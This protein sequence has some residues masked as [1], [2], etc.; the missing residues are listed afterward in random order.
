MNLS[1]RAR[2]TIW[3]G[4]VMG[5]SLAAFGALTFTSISDELN[6]GLDV[7]L[8]KVVQGL[9]GLIRTKAEESKEAKEEAKNT[10]KA[11]QARLARAKAAA[12]DTSKD[13]LA[14]LRKDSLKADTTVKPAIKPLPAEGIEEDSKEV[15]EEV[16]NVWTA[17]YEFI[18]LNPRNFM[19]QV[20]DSTGTIVYRSDNLGEDSLHLSKGFLELAQDSIAQFTTI[21]QKI[22]HRKDPQ[23]IRIAVAKSR[24]AVIIAGYPLDEIQSSTQEYFDT[25]ILLVPA[26]LLVSIV[27]GWFLAKKSLRPVDELTRTA[28]DITASNLSRRL[29]VPKSSDEIGRLSETLNDMISRLESSFE[30]I[31]QF[32]ADASHELRTPLT[33]LTGEMELALRTEKSHEEYQEV[34]SSALQEVLRL[35]RVVEYLLLLSRADMGRINLQLERT[36]LSELLADLVDSATVLGSPKN[37]TITYHHED[38]LF[39]MADQA[40]LYQMLLNL[41]DNAVKYTP[42]DGR[43]MITLHRDG[44]YAEVRVHDTGIGISPEHQKKIFNR[45]YRVDKARSRELGGV[46]LGL[47]IVQWTVHAHEGNISVE[48]EVNKGSTFIVH[49]P[50]IADADGELAET[51][52]GAPKPHRSKQQP[53]ELPKFLKKA[54]GGDE[55]KKK[56]TG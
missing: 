27:G 9:D 3:F 8:N 54:K 49:L 22:R 24:S 46:G 20:M 33:I 39:I 26:V 45:F 1:L 17:I 6:T 18:I 41:I 43:I 21:N 35:S 29:P 31:R 7:S 52:N 40:K 36:N 10:R 42:D 25:L 34:I 51:A 5:I 19:I 48:S 50:L 14:F 11:R 37:I 28:Q 55:H 13:E 4:I 38:H 2:L 12:A 23:P 47:S 56:Q 32:T 16:D 53:F 30:Q 15:P 44:D